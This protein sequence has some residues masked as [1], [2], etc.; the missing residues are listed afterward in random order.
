MKIY[1]ARNNVQ[2]GPYSIAELNI[3][4]SSG[5]VL[6]DDLMWH[7]GMSAWQKIGDITQNQYVYQPPAPPIQAE[8]K[9]PHTHKVSIDEL[10]G[11]KPASS[12]PAIQ[13]T[14]PAAQPVLAFASI[15]ARFGAFLINVLLYLL[16]LLPIMI[17]F[18]QVVDVQQLSQFTQYA[19]IYAYTQTLSQKIPT[20]TATI[21]NIMLFALLTIQ[22]LLI[23]MRG[24]SFGKLVMGVR[25]LDPVTKKLPRF[26]TLVFMRTLTL[27][28][29]YM[30]ATSVFSGIPAIILLTINYIMASK[31]PT[32]QGWHDKMTDTIVAK[33][34]PS[35][36]DKTKL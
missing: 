29:I 16:A 17:A 2:A 15:Q 4:L 35:Q 36:L 27:V 33:A 14:K 3:M 8:N 30:V 7:S 31:S 24:Q 23:T 34:N 10:Y 22:L 20:T 5:E 26:G 28:I 18:I 32:K 6:L 12:N 11:R 1:L 13:T 25:V 21:S 9:A 19:D